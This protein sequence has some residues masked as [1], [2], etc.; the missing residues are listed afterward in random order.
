VKARLGYGL[1]MLDAKTGEIL[2]MKG[3]DPSWYQ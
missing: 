1:A 2:S 3:I